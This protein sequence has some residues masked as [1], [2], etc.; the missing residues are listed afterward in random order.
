MANESDSDATNEAGVGL[1]IG[2][3]HTAGG[4]VINRRP[5]AE[6]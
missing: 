6:S 3:C 2:V 4:Y 5:D 1:D